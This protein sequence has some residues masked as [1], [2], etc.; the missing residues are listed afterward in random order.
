MHPGRVLFLPPA[1]GQMTEG[2]AES[3]VRL[4]MGAGRTRGLVL[5]ER[6]GTVASAA[7]EPTYVSVGSY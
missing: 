5:V 4:A 7:T 2:Q 6:A 3:L 1:A